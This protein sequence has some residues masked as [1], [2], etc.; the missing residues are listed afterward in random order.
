M[1]KGTKEIIAKSQ[2]SR[3]LSP[4]IN[5]LCAPN[6][7]KIGSNKRTCIRKSR[8]GEKSDSGLKGKENKGSL[9]LLLAAIPRRSKTTILMNIV[10]G[11]SDIGF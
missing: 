11:T 2:R 1:N 9:F 6:L 10:S 4:F 8:R 3:K 5:N 7:L